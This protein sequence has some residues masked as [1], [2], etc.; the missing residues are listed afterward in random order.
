MIC[1]VAEGISTDCD[2][3][4]HLGLVRKQKQTTPVAIRLSPIPSFRIS[5]LPNRVI[6]A[7]YPQII[8]AAKSM[9]LTRLDTGTTLAR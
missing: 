2:R 3:G 4:T 1:S 7:A 9:G 6:P 8:L 5:M